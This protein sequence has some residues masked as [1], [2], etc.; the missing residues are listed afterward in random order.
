M[1]NSWEIPFIATVCTLILLF[2]YYRI[3]KSFCCA[4]RGVTS[5][6][7]VGRQPLNGAN[8]DDPSL[9]FHSQGLGSSI[10]NSLPMSQFKKNNEGEHNQSNTD[11]G[12]CLGEFEKGQW[13]KRLPNCS[14]AFHVACI[15]TWFQSHSNCP[16]CRTTVYDLTIH[17]IDTDAEYPVSV[18]TMLE[19]LSREDFIQERTTHYQM[20]RSLILPNSRLRQESTNAS[21]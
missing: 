19:P 20:L 5:R 8:P 18:N 6:N 1:G 17:T 7:R 14:H 2:S 9:Q 16:L 10:I 21:W 4:F 15:D 11:C 13:L 12:V 3:L